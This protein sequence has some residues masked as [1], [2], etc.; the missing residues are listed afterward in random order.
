VIRCQASSSLVP[1]DE[2]GIG[3]DKTDPTA[4]DTVLSVT[5]SGNRD[6]VLPR[7]ASEMWCRSIGS[8]Q[9]GFQKVW[10]ALVSK[11]EL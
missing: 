8:I 1:T 7:V 3:S 2:Q 5:M 9:A 4:T 11:P 6:P 10:D